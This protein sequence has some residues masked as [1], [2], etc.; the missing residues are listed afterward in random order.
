LWL[1][2]QLNINIVDGF[3]EGMFKLK[4]LAGKKEVWLYVTT[5]KNITRQRP[6]NDS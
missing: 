1:I 3:Y 2:D 6:Q 5:I 4:K